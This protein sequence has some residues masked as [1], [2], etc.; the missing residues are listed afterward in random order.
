MF[1]QKSYISAAE[2]IESIDTIFLM[3]EQQSLL[4]IGRKEQ[5]DDAELEISLKIVQ[6]LQLDSSTEHILGKLWFFIRLAFSLDC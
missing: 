2:T 4:Y 5:T 6:Y 1:S 3:W